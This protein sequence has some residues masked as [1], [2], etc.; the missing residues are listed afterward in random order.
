M[1]A[2]SFVS[3]MVDQYFYP[4]IDFPPSAMGWTLVSLFLVFAWYHLDASERG[5]RRSPWLNV[6]VIA[7]AV[8]ALPYYFFR[9]R[10]ARHGA[11]ATGAMLLVYAACT[12]LAAF[13]SAVVFAGQQT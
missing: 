8:V 3:G 7:L 2:T 11:L 9:S 12:L 10:G 1:A 13:G 6:G 5:Y 4:G